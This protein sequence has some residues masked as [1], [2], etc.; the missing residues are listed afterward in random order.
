MAERWLDGHRSLDRSR[1]RDNHGYRPLQWWFVGRLYEHAGARQRPAVLVLTGASGGIDF[2]MAP[3]VAS[4]GYNVL[5]LGYFNA[6]GLPADL[7]E[8]PREY[9]VTAIEWL[10]KRH[11]T[12]DV[13]VLGGSLGAE[14]ALLIGSYYPDRVR[15]VVAWMPTHVVWEGIDARA[16]FGG[17]S[18][19]ASPGKSRWSLN[20]RPLPFVRKFISAARLEKLPAASGDQYAPQFDQPIDPA[21][22]IPVERIRGPVFLV[23]A[24]DDL[25]SPSLRMG[26]EVRARVARRAKGPEVQLLEYPM[27][28]HTIPPPGIGP[29]LSLG[30]TY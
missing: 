8:L 27:A 17:D 20:G 10:A 9:F 16:R 28:G 3:W 14:A 2:Q 24:G 7:L 23:S 19:F 15:V 18:T 11:S 6:T 12:R 13:S 29:N 30:G 1:Q 4:Q 25:A 5:S 22:V 26:R 21:V